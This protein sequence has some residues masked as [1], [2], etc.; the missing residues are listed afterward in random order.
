MACGAMQS[1][2][3][4]AAR[5][6]S[7]WS[8]DMASR[9]LSALWRGCWAPGATP[10]WRIIKRGKALNHANIGKRERFCKLHAGDDFKKWVFLDQFDDYP[11][12]DKDGS[13]M[14]CWQAANSP[15][16]PALGKPWS[17]R[18]YAAVGWNFKSPLFF[19]APSP[20]EGS[21]QHKSQEKFTAKGYI[22]MMQLMKPYLDARF[23][24]GDYV[25]IQ[26]H[27]PQHTA[28]VSKQAMQQMGGPHSH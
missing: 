12:F 2:M 6:R 13:A 3:T 5:S 9:S 21:K 8:P 11:C 20:E 16:E 4:P 18:M 7:G 15:P 19:V 28:G 24:D 22:S 27:A 14:R 23:P 17:F 1:T 25:L 10:S 26:D